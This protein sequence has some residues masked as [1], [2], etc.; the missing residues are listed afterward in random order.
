[1]RILVVGAGATGGYFGGRLA[2]AG[3]DVTF[4]VRPARAKQL[5]ADGLR[6]VSPYGDLTLAPQLVTSS[7]LSSPFDLVLLAVKAYG[8]EQAVTDLAPAVGPGTMILPV[9]NG[10]RHLEVLDDR[11]GPDAVLGGVCFIAATVDPDGHIVQLSGLQELCYG[12]RRDPWS[13]RIDAL[14][15]DLRGAGFPARRSADIVSA[16]WQKWVFLAGL[17]AT[18]CL[19]RGTVG[20]I[21]AAPGGR[22]FAGRVL[23]ECAAV[24]AASGH[25]VRD[26]ALERIRATL[27]E[28]GSA[29]ASS[30]FRDLQ[31]DK[32]VEVDHIL[33][34]LIDRARRLG[35]AVPLLE[36]AFTHLTV[37]QHRLAH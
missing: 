29:L 14:D 31:Q 20:E 3:R 12:D 16:M 13:T 8:L 15:E 25:S 24:A 11:F 6:I 2:A 26:G 1:M 10:M 21:E 17:A 30:M 22:E 7:E 5:D 4:L 28:P 23:A 33:G 37:Y 19:M 34:D 27:T 35:V 18:T 32:S 9:L 36:V